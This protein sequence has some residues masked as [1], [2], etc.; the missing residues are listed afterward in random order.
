MKR[1]ALITGGA[2]GIGREVALALGQ[3]G[4]QVAVNYNSSSRE[5]QTLVGELTERGIPALMVQGDVS[6]PEEAA[7]AVRRV[8]EEMGSVDI[9]VNNAGISR[10]SL[11][12][13]TSDEDFARTMEVNMYGT[14]YCS[15]AVARQMTKNRWGRII[16]ISSV[17]G[18]TGNVGQA[19]YS[20]SKAAVFGF[21][22]SLALELAGRSVTAN[23]IAP[24]FIDTDMTRALDEEVRQEILNRIPLKRLGTAQEVARLVAFLASEDAGYM[25]GQTLVLDG[26]L[27]L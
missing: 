23:A 5:A 2:R 7:E 22:R 18:L 9:L 17:V 19:A 10:D 20:A 14:F 21:T 27:S 12:V 13:R 11:L 8:Q 6:R 15:R 16:N 3:A 26:G 24:G 25:T 1:T 4:H